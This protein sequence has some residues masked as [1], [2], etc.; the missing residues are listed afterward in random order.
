MPEAIQTPVM[1][2]AAE[3]VFATRAEDA[4]PNRLLAASVS[5]TELSSSEIEAKFR[6]LA[7]RWKK[8]APF[9]SI[10]DSCTLPEYEGIKKLGIAAVKLIL[11][12]LQNEPDEWFPAL[13]FLTGANP[14]ADK[15]R[16]HFQAVTDAWLSWGRQRGLI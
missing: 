1:T 13:E 2:S 8:R 15:D 6:E 16:G 7:T 12:E 11:Q 4:E 3:Y 9:L 10:R 5:S 14:V